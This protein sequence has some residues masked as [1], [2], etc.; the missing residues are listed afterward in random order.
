MRTPE[1]S[2]R[3]NGTDF[4]KSLRMSPEVG[5]R[6]VPLMTLR[7][8]LPTQHCSNYLGEIV[9]ADEATFKNKNKN[10]KE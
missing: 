3:Q 7:F 5:T 2:A 10:R 6:N 8:I 4:M 1:V 9:D